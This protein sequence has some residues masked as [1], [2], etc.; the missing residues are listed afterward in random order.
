M[1]S[2]LSAVLVAAFFISGCSSSDLPMSDIPLQPKTE[3]SKLASSTETVSQSNAVKKAT[4]YL[5]IFAFSR[6]GLIKQLEFDGF[7]AGDAAYGTDAQKANWDNQAA[8]KAKVYLSTFAFSRSGLIKQL[9]YDGFT[10]KEAEYG[11]S[12]NGF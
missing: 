4:D 3:N 11:A 6:S 8:E 7:S 5:S 10:Q 9:L 12:A 2:R 1:R